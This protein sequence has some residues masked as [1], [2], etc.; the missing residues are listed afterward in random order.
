MYSACSIITDYTT[1][2]RLSG[3]IYV[4]SIA[5]GSNHF[6]ST[7][8]RKPSHKAA[9]FSFPQ[10]MDNSITIVYDNSHDDA[11]YWDNSNDDNGNKQQEWENQ[12]ELE[13]EEGV[14]KM[15]VD[16]IHQQVKGD[17]SEWNA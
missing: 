4:G 8:M 9:P 6:P 1:T 17:E 15:A 7:G 16:T 5:P 10:M 3:W 14:C 12:Q 13:K 11:N 2:Q